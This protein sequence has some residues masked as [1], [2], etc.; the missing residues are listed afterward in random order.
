MEEIFKS[1]L[2]D[3]HV[4]SKVFKAE[5]KIEK[6]IER[7]NADISYLSLIRFPCLQAY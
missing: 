7:G 5:F 6:K 4:K 3:T 2:G 1:M